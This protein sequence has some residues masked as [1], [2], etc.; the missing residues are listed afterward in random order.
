MESKMDDIIPGN[1][2][3]NIIF[4]IITGGGVASLV[5][6]YFD[7]LTKKRAEYINL[8][9]KRIEM[10]SKSQSYLTQIASGYLGIFSAIKKPPNTQLDCRLIIYYICYILHKSE[11]LRKE[12]GGIIQ[13]YDLNTERIVFD[14]ILY[15]RN[16]LTDEKFENKFDLKLLTMLR[17]LVDENSNYVSYVKKIKTEQPKVYSIAYNW[18]REV[19]KKGQLLEVRERSGWF[20]QL[21]YM[22]L[23]FM[24]SLHYGEKNVENYYKKQMPLDKN[25]LLHILAEYPAYYERLCRYKIAKNSFFDL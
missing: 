18:L 7:W 20:G 3:L 17:Q 14:S 2:L 24:Y 19:E 12:S 11:Q 4:A 10:F 5:G 22:E 25:F 1:A 13:F 23:N 8:T 9:N 15:I 6:Y 16:K 21:V